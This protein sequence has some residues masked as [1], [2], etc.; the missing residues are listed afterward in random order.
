MI[1]EEFT[2]FVYWLYIIVWILVGMTFCVGITWGLLAII[3]TIKEY[4][5]E[6]RH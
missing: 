4:I 5:K 3:E 2:R 1:P 6:R